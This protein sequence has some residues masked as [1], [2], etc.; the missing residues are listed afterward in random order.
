MS[1]FIVN[2]IEM[3]GAG[4]RISYEYEVSD[5]IK[6]YFKT[7]FF[8]EYDCSVAEV[9]E[10]ILIIPLLANILPISWLAGFDITINTLDRQF[11]QAALDIKAVFIKEFP[12]ILNHSS[13]LMVNQL[14]D[15][16]AAYHRDKV[17]KDAL[18]FSGGVDAYASYFNHQQDDMDLI[19]IQ[20]ADIPLNDS[21]QWATAKKNINNEVILQ[22]NHKHYIAMNCRDFY[23]YRVKE[24]VYG[25]GWWGKVQHGLTLTCAVAPL[26][27]KK[28]YHSLYI[29]AT[30][31]IGFQ[32]F[33]GSMPDI[34]NNVRWAGTQVVHDGYHM[35]R[36]D[37]VESIIQNAERLEKNVNLRV[38]YSE[39]NNGLN[40]NKCEK[41]Y[42]TIFALTL[43]GRNPNHFGFAVDGSVYT[44]IEALWAKGFA[45]EGVRYDWAPMLSLLSADNL[46]QFAG[47]NH[48]TERHSA[49]QHNT[50]RHSAERL[51]DSLKVALD[52]PI[53]ET[54]SKVDK[55]KRAIIATFPK[56][57][58]SY[59]KIRELLR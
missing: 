40:C 32:V 1:N 21:K 34:D 7:P 44:H 42:R 41:C 10:S 6:K 20:G 54:D 25:G 11:Y 36:L 24:L 4:T 52:A 13:S 50:E 9:P 3:T 2:S 43:F 27:Y 28:G 30:D 18:L 26:A 38:C 57:F 33:W 14:V 49:E 53:T 47:H 39:L 58:K 12:E 16:T 29:A 55:G 51:K 59:L 45:N 15:N 19:L 5:D 35:H 56:T 31:T 17:K 37:K 46:Y 22:Q 48:N 8:I 23:T